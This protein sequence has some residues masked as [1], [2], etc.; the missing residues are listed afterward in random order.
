MSYICTTDAVHKALDPDYVPKTGNWISVGNGVYQPT[1]ESQSDWIPT[2]NT[3]VPAR[4]GQDRGVGV[5][6]HRVAWA[7]GSKCTVNTSEHPQSSQ[8]QAVLKKYAFPYINLDFSF[9]TSDNA[10]ITITKGKDQY[11]SWTY[12]SWRAECQNRIKR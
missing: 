1:A 4:Q 7:G 2:T 6:K 3:L 5:P 10:D 12:P 9:T 11:A 8:I